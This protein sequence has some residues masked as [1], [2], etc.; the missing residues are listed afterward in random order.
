MSKAS[1]KPPINKARS[2][3]LPTP[4]KDLSLKVSGRA[5]APAQL[6]LREVNGTLLKETERALR[7]PGLSRKAV[8]TGSSVNSY[9]VNPRNPSQYIR[10][11]SNGTKVVGRLVN[12]QFR[13]VATK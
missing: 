3:I 5:A 9:S 6:K 11:R 2:V 13:P 10:E 8:F 1:R 7:R 4:S 12:G